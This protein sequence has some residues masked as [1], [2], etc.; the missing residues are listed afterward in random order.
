MLRITSLRKRISDKFV[1]SIDSLKL[2]EGEIIALIG[3]NGSGKTLLINSI[4][5]NVLL[6]SG[7]IEIDKTNNKLEKWKKI[8]GVYM[9]ENYLLD[10]MTSTEFLSFIGSF[11]NIY[12]KDIPNKLE[13]YQYFL[14]PEFH[15]IKNKVISK[16]S[17]GTKDKIGIIAALVCNPKLLI[18]DEPFSHLDTP[19][20]LNLIELLNSMSKQF[21]TTQI[22]TSPNMN[23]VSAFSTRI[24]LMDQGA[25]KYDLSNNRD[26]QL[27]I[28]KYFSL[29]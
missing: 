7:Y 4:L 14:G 27:V 18:L 9:N 22:I 2:H 12:R 28:N 17:R 19:S 20:S 23:V 26:N 11:Y 16:L 8:T 6:D 13:Q 10:F 29:L 3:N 1:L 24:I 25:I 5:N 15:S 21:K